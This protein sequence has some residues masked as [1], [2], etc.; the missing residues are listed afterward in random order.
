MSDAANG[1]R[2]RLRNIL[3]TLRASLD[4][5]ELAL[6]SNERHGTPL[7]HWSVQ[8]ITQEC[9]RLVWHAASLD[10]QQRRER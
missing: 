5:F 4:S 8:V 6:V 7:G 2:A 1:E 10:A 9:G 3:E